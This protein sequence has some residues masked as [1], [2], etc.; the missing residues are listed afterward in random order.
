[1]ASVGL[2]AEAYERAEDVVEEARDITGEDES[3]GVGSADDSELEVDMFVDR[4]GWVRVKASV[5]ALA[6]RIAKARSLV[7]VWLVL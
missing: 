3:D 1:M 7:L 2:S 5:V 4:V 6:E